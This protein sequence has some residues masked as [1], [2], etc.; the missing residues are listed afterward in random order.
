MKNVKVKK[1]AAGI[2]SLLILATGCDGKSALAERWD[3]IEGSAKGN[4]ENMELLSDG[5]GIADGEGITWK[6]ESNRF[7]LTHPNKA[8]SWGYKVSGSELTFTDDGG[9]ILK[10]KKRGAPVNSSNLKDSR[11]SKTYKTVKMRD[12]KVWMAENLNYN[13]SDSKCY[14]N[15]EANC[16]K[17]GRLYNWATA[18]EACPKGWHLPSDAEWSTLIDFIGDGAGTKLK[19]TSG[20]DNNGNGTD[21]FGFSALPGGYGDSFGDFNGVGDRGYWWGSTER[22]ASHAYRRYMGINLTLVS[23]YYIGETFLLSVRCLQD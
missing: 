18:K 22:I 13:A 2:L 1:M 4:P 21:N 6:T 12:G 23:K 7:Y 16:Q 19:A 9:K 8:K 14:D 5:T 15:E 10:Y 11:D 17:Y 20:W 3:L